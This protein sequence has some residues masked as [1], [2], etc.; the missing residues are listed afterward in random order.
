MNL[1]FRKATLIDV[2]RLWE[3]RRDSIIELAPDGMARARA[4]A[5]AA[6]LTVIGMEQ[7]FLKTEIWVAEIDE[8]IAGWIAMRHDCI[9]GLYTD[10]RYARQSIGT[11]LLF[12]AERL[13]SER[14]IEIIRLEA[15]LNA[16]QFYL[17]RGYCQRMSVFQMKRYQWKSGYRR[18]KIQTEALPENDPTSSLAPNRVK[19]RDLH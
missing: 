11:Q 15:S 12:L 18:Q 19:L 10:P 7:R 1:H 17:R 13:I 4:E 3:L 16:E 2:P 6:T 8:I 9:N 5:W 14:A